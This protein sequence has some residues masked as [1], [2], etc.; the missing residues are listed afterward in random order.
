MR[1]EVSSSNNEDNDSDIELDS[2]QE[3]TSKEEFDW[4]NEFQDHLKEDATVHG[5]VHLAGRN[6]PNKLGL[7]KNTNNTSFS[8]F[9]YWRK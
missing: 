8:E 4:D 9:G 7:P 3:E 2:F 5:N 1:Y 6:N